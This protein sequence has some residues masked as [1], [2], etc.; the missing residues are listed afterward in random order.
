MNFSLAP[1]VTLAVL[2]VYSIASLAVNAFLFLY[3]QRHIVFA[4]YALLPSVVAVYPLCMAAWV[5]K[6]YS[7]YAKQFS[8]SKGNTVA[9]YTSCR[10]LRELSGCHTGF[11]KQRR[12]GERNTIISAKLVCL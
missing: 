10:P 4:F 6:Q 12:V 3:K 11:F 1:Q 2:L 9:V 5:T 8:K 7:W